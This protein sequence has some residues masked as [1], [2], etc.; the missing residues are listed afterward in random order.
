MN[1]SGGRTPVGVLVSGRGTNLQALLDACEQPDY[2]AHIAVVVSNRPGAPALDRARARRVPSVVVDHRSFRTRDAFEE[3]LVA[4]LRSHG[5]EWVCLAGFM[6]VLGPHFL[7]AFPMRVLNI[8]PSLL[9]AFPGLHAQRQAWEHGVKISGCTVHL[10]TEGVDEGPIVAQAAV[11]VYDDDTADTLAA[12]ILAEEHRLYPLALRWAVE[13]RLRIEGRRV[14][15]D[16]EAHN[17]SAG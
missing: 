9:P 17:A 3:A 13:G 2:P 10:V 6:R 7:Q 12:R 4:P 5:V 16:R 14:R 15:V 11:P 8:H 1:A